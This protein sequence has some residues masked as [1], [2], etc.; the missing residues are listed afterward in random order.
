M[1]TMSTPPKDQAPEALRTHFEALASDPSFKLSRSRRGTYVNPAVARDWKW[2]QLGASHA[3][4]PAPPD[5]TAMPEHWHVV[6][7]VNGDNILCIGAD[8]LHGKRELSEAEENAIIGAAQHLLAFVGYGLPPS[9][10]DPDS[11]DEPAAPAPELPPGYLQGVESVAKMIE[12]KADDFAQQ[13]GSDDMGSL[14]FGRGAH[15]DA[16]L[17]YHSSLAELAD[18]A[19]AML[20]AAPLPPAAAQEPEGG[21]PG[22]GGWQSHAEDMERQRDYWRQRAKLMS[23]HQDGVCWYWQGDG[24]DYPESLV[25]SLPVVIRADQ[26]RALVAPT[27]AA[28]DVLAERQRQISAEGWTP[29]HD[30]DHDT[31]QMAAAASCYALHAET[32]PH[33]ASKRARP[34]HWPWSLKWWKPGATRRMLVKAGALILA[35]IERLDRADQRGVV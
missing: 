9:S 6:V 15:A 33:L 25:N 34:A 11:D 17:D 12:K 16:K 7:S 23:E 22:S 32:G 35:E 14:S 29:E 13:Y 5:T 18:E 30:D 8:Y 2:F 24:S 28:R 21:P 3:R 10:F 4:P 26:L 19:R 27:P 31:G 1:T 20:A